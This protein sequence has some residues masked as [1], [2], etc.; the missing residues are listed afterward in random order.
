LRDTFDI[1]EGNGSFETK[2][3]GSSIDKGDLGPT[4]ASFAC[5]MNGVGVGTTIFNW[6]VTFDGGGGSFDVGGALGGVG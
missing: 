1:V 3:A 4:T 6:G 5:G 2:G